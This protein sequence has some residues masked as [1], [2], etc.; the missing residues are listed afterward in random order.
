[1]LS[2]FLDRNFIKRRKGASNIHFRQ[3]L[4]HFSGSVSVFLNKKDE[5]TDTYMTF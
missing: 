5:F 3:D 4:K 1:M 2:Y